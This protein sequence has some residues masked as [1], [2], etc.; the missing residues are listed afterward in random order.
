VNRRGWLVPLTGA[1]FV[2]LVIVA[3]VLSGEPPSADDPVQEIVDFYV[4]EK[5]SL[6]AGA[7]VA[8]LAMVM[9]VFFANHLRAAVRETT[10]SATILV[11]AAIMAVG[12]AIDVTITIALT[13]SVEDI[14]PSAVQ[15]LQ[16]LWDNDFVPI[17]L[18]TV[19]FLLSAGISVVQSG[20]VPRWLGWV[21][22]ALAV[23]GVT[24]L[25]FAAFLGGGLWIL[26][27]SIL[28]T[29]RARRP[30]AAPAAQ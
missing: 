18:G 24:P 6:Q 30:G 28:L 1:A 7:L 8:G 23:I 26:V 21:A 2:V 16:A 15:A 11:G 13:E 3:I 5:G 9:L 14:D 10:T 25:G 20:V 19:I 4:D 22:I 17:A 27:V 12:L 29:L